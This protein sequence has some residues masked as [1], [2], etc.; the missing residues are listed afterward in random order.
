VVKH[1]KN[2]TGRGVGQRGDRGGGGETCPYNNGTKDAANGVSARTGA[3]TTGAKTAE[4][5]RAAG[6]ASRGRYQQ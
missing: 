6:S 2:N 1:T 3:I 4:E 5:E